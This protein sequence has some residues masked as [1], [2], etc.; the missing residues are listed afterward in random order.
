LFTPLATWWMAF[1][2]CLSR[3]FKRLSEKP[4]KI[5]NFAIHILVKQYIIRKNTFI[6]KG[7]K[8]C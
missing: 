7:Y 1:K 3:I 8:Q 6:E 2:Q 5:Y 4:L